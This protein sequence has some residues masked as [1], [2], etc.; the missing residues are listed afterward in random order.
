MKSRVDIALGRPLGLWFFQSSGRASVVR[1]TK[2]TEASNLAG[3]EYEEP[4]EEEP[5]SDQYAEERDQ[6][7]N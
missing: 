2:A 5:S 1:L 4:E 7:F 3:Y 6:A